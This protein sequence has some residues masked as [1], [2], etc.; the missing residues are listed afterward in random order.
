MLLPILEEI[1]SY[2][3]AVEKKEVQCDVSS[4]PRCGEPASF[5]L[6]ERRR[7]TYL[8]VVERF[9]KTVLSLL[10]RWKC[11]R[12]GETFT[13]YPSFALPG[14]RYL[15][16]EVFRRA[17]RYVDGDHE[18]YRKAVKVDGLPVFHEGRGKEIDERSLAHTTLHRWLA[19]FST[20]AGTCRE[21]LGL[22][23][24]K[25]PASGVFR[26]AFPIVPW[27]Y[28]SDERRRVLQD[29]RRLLVA[30]GEYHSLFGISIFP[31]LATL[32]GWR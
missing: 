24:Q 20:L 15:R 16:Q 17:G 18:S 30:E 12:C 13:L 21:A 4:C 8:V 14:K 10:T 6:H 32:C 1:Q 19:L 5:K 29:S 25:S 28:R 2:T 3:G 11:E 7:R 23:R 9:V 22:I 31:R 27:K 26:K